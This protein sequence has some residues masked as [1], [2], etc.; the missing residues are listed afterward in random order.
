[1]RCYELTTALCLR[2]PPDKSTRRLCIADAYQTSAQ[3]VNVLRLKFRGQTFEISY[4]SQLIQNAG[5]LKCR[6]WHAMATQEEA[7]GRRTVAT[8]FSSLTLISKVKLS[9]LYYFCNCFKKDD[10]THV[11]LAYFCNKQVTLLAVELQLSHRCT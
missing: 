6:I 7:Y 4:F 3:I 11:I 8:S 1:M 9:V 5:Y 10:L 2:I